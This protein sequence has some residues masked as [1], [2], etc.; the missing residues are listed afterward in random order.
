[1]KPIIPA[2]GALQ[3]EDWED[4]KACL[5]YQ[6]TSTQVNSGDKVKGN[7]KGEGKMI[8]GKVFVYT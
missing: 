4:I 5:G 1:M 2:L 8:L 7:S 6:V 3:Q